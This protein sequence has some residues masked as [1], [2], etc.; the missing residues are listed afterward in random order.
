MIRDWV[1]AMANIEIALVGLVFF[2][3]L[4]CGLLLFVLFS[5]KEKYQY[6]QN[7]PLGDDHGRP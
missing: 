5:R 3:L 7:L 4:F 2:V 6:L 1:S